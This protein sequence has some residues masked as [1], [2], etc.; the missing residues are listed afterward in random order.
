MIAQRFIAGLGDSGVL[1]GS[2]GGTTDGR[3]QMA[4]SYVSSGV[5]SY[6]PSLRDSFTLLPLLTQR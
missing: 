3:G 6:Q 1:A 4:H 2:P 5:R